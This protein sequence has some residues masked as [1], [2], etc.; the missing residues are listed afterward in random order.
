MGRLRALAIAGLAAWS[1]LAPGAIAMGPDGVDVEVAEASGG[2]AVHGRF[3]VAAGP[4]LAWRVLT[5]YDGLGRFVPGMRSRLLERSGPR[6]ALVDQETTV[7]FLGIRRSQRVLLRLDESPNHRLGFDDVAH[8]DFASYHGAWTLEAGPEG[9]EV[10][11]EAA[12]RPVWVPP[13]VGAP[14]LTG[15]VET[16]LGALRREMVRR[17]AEQP[18]SFRPR[19]APR[20]PAFIS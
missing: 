1:A 3:R 9:T 11:Y 5:D 13:L 15:T 4:A 6:T 16:L 20:M 19:Q 14:V 8:G 17:A 7:A 10:R 12:A 2:F 18:Q